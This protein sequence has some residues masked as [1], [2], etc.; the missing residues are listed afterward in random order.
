MNK[1][2]LSLN[3]VIDLE[4]WSG[5]QESLSVV[6]KAAII[7]VD[8]KGNPIT[9]HSRCNKFC[10]LVRANPEI[11]K[12]CK[13]C[14]ARGGLEAVRLNEPYIYLCHYNIVDIAIP[15]IIDGKYIGAVM[16]GQIKLKDTKENDNLEQIVVTNNS[17]AK[18]A[19][20]KYKEYYDELPVMTY[21]EVKDIANM[22]FN[23]C[24]YL[25]EEALEK[26]LIA[27]MYS[28][29]IHNQGQITTNT[30]SGYTMKNIKNARKEISNALINS[31][32]EKQSEDVKSIKVSKTLEPAIEYIYKNKS[33]HITAHKIA[34]ICHLSTSYFSRLF[35]KETGENFSIYVSRL[36][37]EWSKTLLEETDMT[38]NE[39]SEELGFNE[40]GYFIK[41]FKKYEGVTPLIYRKY[42]SQK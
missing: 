41:V 11:V 36:K 16:A 26:N 39:I 24:N 33:E 42:C 15:I 32:V 14:D 22:L 10:S 6:T 2:N 8:Y 38:I 18:D 13:K 34:K 31:Y 25:V 23:L 1:E 37:I 27:D 20:I 4:K 17:L 7:V 30:L 35:T 19:L 40:S 28:E 29:S 3:K 9:N 12:Y 5:L 21:K